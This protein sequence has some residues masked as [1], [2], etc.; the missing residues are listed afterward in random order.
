MN[1][2][3]QVVEP[4]QELDLALEIANRIA[5][6]APLAVQATLASARALDID[7]ERSEV[8]NRL[9]QLLQTRDVQRGMQAFMTKSPAVFEGN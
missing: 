5:A 2:V 6:Q 1:I 9:G 7:H 3:T 4:G 8:L